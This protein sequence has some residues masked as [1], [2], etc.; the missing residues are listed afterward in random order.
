MKIFIGCSGFLYREWKPDFYPP[1]IPQ[2]KWLEYYSNKFNSLEI[3]STFYKFPLEK[4]L[5]KFYDDTSKNFRFSLKVPRLITHYK[6]LKDCKSLAKDF[7]DVVRNG[8]ENKTGCILYQFPPK[9]NFNDERLQLL[10]EILDP[11][12]MNVAEFRNAT[13]YSTE[14][15]EQLA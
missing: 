3:N 6:Q 5:K 11:S 14:I 12:F 1:D 2:R 4:N 10:A 8:L 15:L 7:Y 9:F 13:W